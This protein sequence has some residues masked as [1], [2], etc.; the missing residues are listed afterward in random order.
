MAQQTI[1]ITSE[2]LEAAYRALTPSQEGFT[3]DLMASNTIV[4]IINLTDAAEG[5]DLPLS[6]T[7]AASRDGDR[8]DRETAGTNLTVSTTTG[9]SILRGTCTWLQ[10]DTS[11]NSYSTRIY[12]DDG[13]TEYNLFFV[14]TL[15]NVSVQ[16]VNTLPI[17][18]IYYNPSGFELKCDVGTYS[19]LDLNVRQIAQIDETLVQPTP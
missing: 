10:S 16:T 19:K 15:A 8:F 17:E 1:S 4:P 3:E 5:A 2:S 14:K 9:W 6:L 18:F 12:L 11:A 13:V 7:F